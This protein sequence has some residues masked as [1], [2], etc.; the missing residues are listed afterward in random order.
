MGRLWE[1][2]EDLDTKQTASAPTSTVMH[3]KATVQADTLD[4]LADLLTVS[5]RKLTAPLAVASSV[6][7]ETIFL[8]ANDAQAAGVRASGGVPYTPE[9]VDLLWELYQAVAP[10]VWCERLRLIHRAKKRFRGKL[11]LRCAVRCPSSVP[12]VIRL[13]RGGGRAGGARWW[14]RPGGP[15]GSAGTI[16]R[17]GLHGAEPGGC[18]Y[19]VRL[20]KERRAGA[21]GAGR[22]G[23]R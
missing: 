9:E 14:A 10:E 15:D 7:D 11:E 13:S 5:V 2:V 21:D 17:A 8:C 6:L 4:S 23:G 19:R 20:D 12:G 3:T 22:S 18:K 1:L 16:R